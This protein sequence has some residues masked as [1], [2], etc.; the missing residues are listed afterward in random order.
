M[1]D[2][3]E[4]PAEAIRR[5]QRSERQRVAEIIRREQIE[6]GLEAARK[7]LIQSDEDELH[8]RPT[9]TWAQFKARVEQHTFRRR[10]TTGNLIPPE[11]EAHGDY[12]EATVIHVETG[13]AT[14]TKRNARSSPIRTL[15]DRGGIDDE[16]ARSAEEIEAIICVLGGD[17]GIKSKFLGIRV[18]DSRGAAHCG[19]ENFAMVRAEIAYSQ[20]RE[21]LPMPRQM[22]IDMISLPQALFNTARSY[23]IGWPV[24]RKRLISALDRWPVIKD[25]VWGAVSDEAIVE[26]QRAAEGEGL[27]RE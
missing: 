20:W 19:M 14:H 4:K 16:Q 6:R 26:A 11:A 5:M 25:R 1:N 2:Q 7:A 24:A 23:R 17:V 21:T 13:T 22:I 27:A 18:D 10:I 15:Y 3:D 8:K 12:R 9:E